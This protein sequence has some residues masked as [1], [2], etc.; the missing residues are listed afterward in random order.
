MDTSDED[1]TGTEPI[2]PVMWSGDLMIDRA[3]AIASLAREIEFS[4]NDDVRALLY[5][6]MDNLLYTISPPRGELNVVKH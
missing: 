2:G 4:T 6:T 1:F 3:L 5:Q